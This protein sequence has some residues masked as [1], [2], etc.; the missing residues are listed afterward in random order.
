M[1]LI[2]APYIIWKI[3]AAG[4]GG[5]CS[6]YRRQLPQ[7]G[8]YGLGQVSAKRKLCPVL[9]KEKSFPHPQPKPNHMKPFHFLLLGV[10]LLTACSKDTTNNTSTSS[11]TNSQSAGQ[12]GTRQ[13]YDPTN[14]CQDCGYS[15]DSRFYCAGYQNCKEKNT[16]DPEPDCPEEKAIQYAQTAGV[17]VGSILNDSYEVRD[18]LLAVTQGGQWYITY[19]YAIGKVANDNNLIT[20]SNYSTYLQ[21]AQDLIVIS[22]Q[23]RFGSATTV[24][25][26]SG[27]KNQAQ[28]F[29][30]QYRALTTNSRTLGYLQA[31]ENDLNKFINKDV[32]YIRNEIGW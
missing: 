8:F 21:F 7:K 6:Q 14:Y 17:P 19:Y 25:V 29:I 12:Q 9:P 10:L 31:I 23:V 27:F 16:P 24:P 4:I 1:A 15:P 32:A 26:G 18:S 28:S 3:A 30:N 5:E 2:L 11:K 20:A 22:N 13:P